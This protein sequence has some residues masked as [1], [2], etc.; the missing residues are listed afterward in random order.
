M[1]LIQSQFSGQNGSLRVTAPIEELGHAVA[2]LNKFASMVGMRTGQESGPQPQNP[3]AMP[4]HKQPQWSQRR[5]GQ[6]PGQPALQGNQL[7]QVTN[8]VLQPQAQAPPMEK[9]PS[10][11]KPGASKVVSAPTPVQAPLTTPRPDGAPL[12]ARENNFSPDRLSIPPKKKR[13]QNQTTK[14]TP[15]T[16]KSEA[17]PTPPTTTSS[18]VLQVTQPR[19][20]QQTPQHA[21]QPEEPPIKVDLPH[22]CPIPGCMFEKTGFEAENKRDGHAEAAHGYKGS[23]GEFCLKSIRACLRLDK[24]IPA[25]V[26]PRVLSATKPT[27]GMTKAPAIQQSFLKRDAVAAAAAAKTTGQAQAPGAAHQTKSQTPAT[28][29]PISTPASKP[30]PTA[31]P[32]TKRRASQAFENTPPAL[33]SGADPSKLADA[34]SHGKSSAEAGTAKAETFEDVPETG[35][36]RYSY[37]T[38]ANMSHIFEQ[39]SLAGYAHRGFDA[40]RVPSP[41]Q[42]VPELTHAGDSPSDAAEPL[43]PSPPR[44]APNLLHWN[45]FEKEP[46]PKFAL[47][48][49]FENEAE[50]RLARALAKGDGEGML[51]MSQEEDFIEGLVDVR[52]VSSVREMVQKGLGPFSLSEEDSALPSPGFPSWGAMPWEEDEY[53]EKPN[54]V[55]FDAGL[56]ALVAKSA[57]KR[58]AQ[59]DALE[60]TSAKAAKKDG[61]ETGKKRKRSDGS[62]GRGRPPHKTPQRRVRRLEEAHL[63]LILDG[64]TTLDSNVGYDPFI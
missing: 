5:P 23:D 3:G 37:M 39:D 53:L 61:A 32:G 36:W 13:K 45:P 63:D 25:T 21:P 14:E 55:E 4:Q 54:L 16:A 6:V 8:P 2:K 20:L 44:P 31:T 47:F 18:P 43:L 51:R 17:Q 27:T 26:P 57:A 1:M 24:P 42:T 46:E 7:A 40:L 62:E 35:P 28:P 56:E 38:R 50:E 9:R 15:T 60:A 22:K 58:A 33:T 19:S 59:L 12:Y 34:G 41:L 48:A 52:G 49:A 64:D 10:S 29:E 11:K 30:Q